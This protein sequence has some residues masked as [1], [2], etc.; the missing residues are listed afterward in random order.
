VSP[1]PAL[2]RFTLG[3]ADVRSAEAESAELLF[4]EGADLELI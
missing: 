3:E 2:A 4:S 1:L